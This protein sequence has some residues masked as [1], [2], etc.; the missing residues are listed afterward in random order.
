MIFDWFR[1]HHRKALTEQPFP[2]EWEE[3]LNR[4]VAQYALLT[5]DEQQRL[6]DDL[7]VFVDEKTWEG[8]GGL[9][10]TDE[11]QVT[12][13][14]QACLLTLNREHRYF[15]NVESILVYPTGYVA[16]GKAAEPGGIVVEGE[17]HRLGEAWSNGPVVLSWQDVE[18]GGMNEKDGHNVVL[19]E[20]AHKLDQNDGAVDG[21]PLLDSDEQVEQWAEVM[22]QEYEKLVQA[23]EHGRATLLD[24]YGATNG[25][26][27]FAVA[28]ECFFEKS[29]QMQHQHPE[30]YELLK[31]YYKQDTAARQTAASEE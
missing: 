11:M 4:N 23:S 31:D 26:E 17:S 12:I 2:P 20:F 6:R 19:H 8:C 14:A 1:E 25:G 3:I 13:A 10:I 24:H 9:E 18:I 22:S 29:V 21:V 16:Q 30:L 5:P 7:R 15:P 28:T 27:F